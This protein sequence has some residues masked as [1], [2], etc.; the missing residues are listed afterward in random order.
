M[1]RNGMNNC[2]HTEMY[3][4]WYPKRMAPKQATPTYGRTVPDDFTWIL[5]GATSSTSPSVSQQH[6]CSLSGKI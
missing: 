2:I 5:A 1:K 4:R 6:E 3:P